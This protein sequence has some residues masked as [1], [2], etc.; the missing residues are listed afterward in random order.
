MRMIKKQAAKLEE[1]EARRERLVNRVAKLDLKIEEQK[2]K[3]VQYYG[4]QGINV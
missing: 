1:L 4:Q 3:I 2:E